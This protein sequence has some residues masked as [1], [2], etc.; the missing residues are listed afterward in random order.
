MHTQ[1][2]LRW[3]AAINITVHFNTVSKILS[4]KGLSEKGAVQKVVDSEVLRRCD[5]Y[6]PMQ[7]G[8]LKKSGILGTLIGSGLVQ[9]RCIYAHRQYYNNAGKGKQGT[10]KGGL[11]GKF[12]FERMKADHL[13]DIV[14]L[15]KERAGEPD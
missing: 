2:I 9:Y 10:T 3:C 15:A 8:F 4:D 7:T 1:A 5:P 13:Q 14:K 6:V 11:R 12:W